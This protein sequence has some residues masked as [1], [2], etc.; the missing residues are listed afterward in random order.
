MYLCAVE[1]KQLSLRYRGDNIGRNVMKAYNY[2]L[3]VKN[4]VRTWIGDNVKFS[5]WKGDRE[6]LEEYLN[7]ELFVVDSVTGNGSGSYTFNTWKAEENICHNI[8]LLGE[9]CEEFG[10]DSAQI[11]KKGAEAC[12]VTIRC[13]LLGPAVAAVLD[14]LEEEGRI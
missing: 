12:D 13:Y 3:A 2:L 7:D 4:D 8:E 14:E 5:E 10:D 11:L 9:A 6:G 1:V